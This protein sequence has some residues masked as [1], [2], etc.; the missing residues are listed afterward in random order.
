[1]GQQ[2]LEGGEGEGLA[3]CMYY[4][5]EVFMHLQRKKVQWRLAERVLFLL[6]LALA[7]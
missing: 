3:D 6:N 7:S 2:G 5:S 1:M 4:I